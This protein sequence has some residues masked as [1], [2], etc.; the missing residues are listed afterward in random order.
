LCVWGGVQPDLGGG[1]Q[2]LT[3]G[4]KWGRRFGE[5]EYHKNIGGIPLV[6]N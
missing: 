2:Y 1:E 6:E 3:G 5:R 4:F